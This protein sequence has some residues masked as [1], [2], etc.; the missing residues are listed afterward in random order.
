M[1][2]VSWRDF[3]LEKGTPPHFDFV[4]YLYVCGKIG[5]LD[6]IYFIRTPL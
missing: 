1:G 5:I 2:S 3:I 6:Y 4:L